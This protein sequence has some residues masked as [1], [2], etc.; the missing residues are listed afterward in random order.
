MRHEDLE[1]QRSQ[2]AAQIVLMVPG[3]ISEV[4]RMTSK[5]A[6]VYLLRYTS[7]A[8]EPT[9]GQRLNGGPGRSEQDY[10]IQSHWIRYV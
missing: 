7:D 2:E 3:K 1:R 6:V 9:F 8:A 4:C 10:F 5:S